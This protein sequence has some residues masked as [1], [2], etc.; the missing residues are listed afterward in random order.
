M[1]HRGIALIVALVVGTTL[2][3]GQR[4][5]QSARLH[6]L[7]LQGIDLTW[8]EEYRQAD[9]LFQIA[10]REFPWHPA[11]FVYRAGVLQS[12]A[13]DHEQL[14]NRS[15]FDSL[16]DAGRRNAERL[17]LKGDEAG[18]GYFFLGTAS[19]YDSYAYV[20]R[21][22][23]VRGTLKGYSSVNAFEK[24]IELDSALTDATG[25]IGAFYYWRSR[26]TEYFNW[27]P[28]VG[29]RRNEGLALLAKAIAKGV[30]NRYT[31]L[32]LMV[33]ICIDAGDYDQAIHYSRIALAKYPTNRM[34][35]WGLS[36]ALQKKGSLQEAVK[37]Y[38]SLLLAIQNDPASN[39]Y[40]EF[41]CRL[42]LAEVLAAL[43]EDGGARANLDHVLSTDVGA[44]S[45]HLRARARDNLS[46]ARMLEQKLGGRAS[47]TR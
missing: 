29:D 45:E 20:S 7:V 9:S 24:A 47:R 44:F 17:C 11:G 37:A 14:V 19:G 30:Y 8:R 21:N 1:V 23:W 34:F 13:M 6:E 22:D 31:A 38:G 5:L 28:F 40:N 3:P 16:L 15:A 27:L 12:F 39:S 33:T 2:L 42:N 35:L 26:K 46:R 4:I 10:T 41:I 36:T 32:N 18:W 43:E 25:G